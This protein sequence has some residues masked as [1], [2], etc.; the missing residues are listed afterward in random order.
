MQHLGFATNCTLLQRKTN[1]WSRAGS[2]RTMNYFKALCDGIGRERLGAAWFARW[3]GSLQISDTW[4]VRRLGGTLLTSACC[5][6]YACWVHSN[7]K[8]HHD[9]TTNCGQLH[10]DRAAQWFWNIQLE[11]TILTNAGTAP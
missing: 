2:A 10:R 4:A 9:K 11:G 6:P 5:D 8:Q 1:L 3:D 7:D